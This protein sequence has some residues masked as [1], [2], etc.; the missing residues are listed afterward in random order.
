MA[1]PATL[2]NPHLEQLIDKTALKASILKSRLTAEPRFC[3]QFLQSV[4]GDQG[5]RRQ[6]SSF[7][8]PRRGR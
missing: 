3:Q 4:K 5:A 6:G 2:Y 1:V 8:P 7:P